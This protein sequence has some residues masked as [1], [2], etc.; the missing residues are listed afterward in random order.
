MEETKPTLCPLCLAQ[1]EP[2][3]FYIS[4]LEEEDA[5]LSNYFVDHWDRLS[6]Y[7][8][9]VNSLYEFVITLRDG[10]EKNSVISCKQ[11]ISNRQVD[12]VKIR[13]IRSNNVKRLKTFNLK[14]CTY[15]EKISFPKQEE[16]G[17][18][19]LSYYHI[20]QVEGLSSL[21]GI[22]IFS[23]QFDTGKKK[24][25]GKHF[26]AIVQRYAQEEKKLVVGY[27]H[28]ANNF[29]DVP[30]DI[31]NILLTFISPIPLEKLVDQYV[32]ST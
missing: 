27:L 20:K 13:Q 11:G 23:L 7:P 32:P 31:F 12:P 6:T 22:G 21:R 3:D 25:D 19:I 24:V 18:L 15:L 1:K 10:A 17:H 5:L 28:Q 16:I 8:K 26:S 2:S 14:K 30:I 4:I 9:R 29:G